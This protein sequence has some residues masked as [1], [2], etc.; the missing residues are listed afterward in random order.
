MKQIQSDN[1][2]SPRFEANL[3]R[4]REDELRHA[5]DIREHYERKLERTNNLYMELSAVLLQ[6]EQRERDVLK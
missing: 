4:K 2:S 3:I 6:L 5:Q 1:S